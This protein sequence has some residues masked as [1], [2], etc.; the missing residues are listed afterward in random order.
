[1]TTEHQKV[2]HAMGNRMGARI[3]H[4]A[5][6]WLHNK[7]TKQDVRTLLEEASEEFTEWLLSTPPTN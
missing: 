4:I 7:A 1:M 6:Q 3:E 2:A 5:T